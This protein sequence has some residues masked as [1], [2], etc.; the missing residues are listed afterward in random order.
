MNTSLI[1][2]ENVTKKYKNKYVLKNISLDITHP[3]I[4]GFSGPNGSGKSMTFKTILGFVRPS[5]GK[6]TVNGEIIRKETLFAHDIGFSMSEFGVLA[7]KSGT[8]NLELLSILAK[9]GS[10][11]IPTLLRYV[12]LDPEDDKKVAS[13]SLGMKQRLSIATALIGNH[14]ILI[15]DEP[16]NALDEDGQVFLKKLVL[17]LF[18]KGKTILISSHDSTFLRSVAHQIYFLNDGK[19]VKEE[20]V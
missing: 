13:Y 1:K 11:S 7:N 8:E 19:I 9:Q 20:L 15:L 5:S 6:V 16:T 14:K 12:G 4:Y 10:E 2:I 17:D 3:G 18:E